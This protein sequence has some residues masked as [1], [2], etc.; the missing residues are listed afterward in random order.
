MSA[1]HSA[2][3]AIDAPKHITVYYALPAG[4][5]AD[6]KTPDAIRHDI[7]VT[8]AWFRGQTA[9]RELR[10]D[11]HDGV[12][13][14]ETRRLTA[15]T[16]QLANQEDAPKL[17]IDEFRRPDGK[18]LDTIPLVFIPVVRHTVGGVTDCGVSEGAFAIVWAGSCGYT[19]SINSAWPGGE[20][21]I[22]AHELMHALGAVPECAPHYGHAGH[23]TDDQ[24]DIMYWNA[25]RRTQ[26]LI[27]LDPR[28]DDY[29]DTHRTDCWDVA[30]HPAWQDA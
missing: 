4:V 15:T 5:T 19:P 24:A 23:V 3:S 22:I 10:I 2:A 29:Y 18:A 7:A 26:D 21:K 9:G 6:A 12:V 30:R 14:V 25:E 1:S 16:A 17:V 11:D 27:A 28:H 13:A 8:Q 20:T